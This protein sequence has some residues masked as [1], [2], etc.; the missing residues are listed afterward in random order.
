TVDGDGAVRVVGRSG[1]ALGTVVVDPTTG[2]RRDTDLVPEP[3]RRPPEAVAELDGSLFVDAGD[4]VWSR[5]APGEPWNVHE[6][7]SA[8]AVTG[9]GVF[10]FAPSYER[11]LV[12]R[13]DGSGSFEP[14]GTIEMEDEHPATVITTWGPGWAFVEACRGSDCRRFAR[15]DGG[16]WG[17]APDLPALP[18]WNGERWWS[19]S[20]F[21]LRSRPPI[22]VSDDGSTWEELPMPPFWLGAD[23]QARAVVLPDDRLLIALLRPNGSSTVLVGERG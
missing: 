17:T 13:W 22:L 10:G 15:P 16:G 2:E 14:V 7:V 9:D 18:R 8:V 6:L 3:G 21:A 11:V 4:R 20:V 23:E 19:A 12:Y 5:P 1:G